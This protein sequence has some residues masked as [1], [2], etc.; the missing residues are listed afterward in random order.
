MLLAS[1]Q[2]EALQAYFDKEVAAGHLLGPVPHQSV[3]VSRMGVI[4]KGRTPGY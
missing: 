3:H 1:D 4:P 2:A